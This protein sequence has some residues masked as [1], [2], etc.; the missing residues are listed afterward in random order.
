MLKE[1]LK[2]KDTDISDIT[3]NNRVDEYIK[4]PV[5]DETK[6]Q[7]CEKNQ[8]CDKR[9]GTSETDG[10][11]VEKVQRKI[12]IPQ[13]QSF[14][15]K[16]DELL[17]VPYS[18]LSESQKRYVA[19]LKALGLSS[20]MPRKTGS[21][22]SNTNKK[23][24]VD[25]SISIDNALME[26]AQKD[27]DKEREYEESDNERDEESDNER[28][29]ESDNERDEGIKQV[30]NVLRKKDT[31]PSYVPDRKK[32]ESDVVSEESS[33]SDV[34]SEESSESDVVSNESLESDVS[35][36]SSE[37]SSEEQTPPVDTKLSNEMLLKRFGVNPPKINHDKED[38]EKSSE[39]EFNS[40]NFNDG[41]MFG[42][43]F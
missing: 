9:F 8:V 7:F 16:M 37:K 31:S 22:I 43:N 2:N 40:Y 41:D 39:Y 4:A 23:K 30:A 35:E 36:E 24:E 38:S 42:L 6:D 3:D 17:D 20:S 19:I 12:T 34:V 13:D 21:P 15:N 32:A 33:E 14:Y 5:C 28:D 27:I 10:L 18:T 26:M 11:C 29:E 25:K 1:K